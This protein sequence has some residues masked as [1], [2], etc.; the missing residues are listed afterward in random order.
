MLIEIS[1]EVVCVEKTIG[2]LRV[3]LCLNEFYF[4]NISMRDT[5]GE[6]VI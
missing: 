6:L 5:V 4:T 1:D 2:L 3:M